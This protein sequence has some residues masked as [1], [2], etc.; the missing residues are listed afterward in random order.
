[1]ERIKQEATQ[2]AWMGQ[3]VNVHDEIYSGIKA[4]CNNGPKETP[5]SW[6]SPGEKR[7]QDLEKWGKIGRA[8]LG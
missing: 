3:S 7:R 5:Y 8:S 4:L 6:V 2:A 1:V